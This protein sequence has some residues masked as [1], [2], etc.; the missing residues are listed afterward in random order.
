MIL[1]PHEE[2][3][4]FR[5]FDGIFKDGR[6]LLGL[7]RLVRLLVVLQDTAVSAMAAPS[8]TSSVGVRVVLMWPSTVW[9][10]VAGRVVVLQLSFGCLASSAASAFKCTTG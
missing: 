10:V 7:L 2:L 1:F 6:V 3:K 5:L 8:P 4:V 9:S